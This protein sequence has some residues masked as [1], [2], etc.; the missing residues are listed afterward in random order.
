MVGTG[1]DKVILQ[2]FSNLNDS[3]SAQFEGLICLAR[4]DTGVSPKSFVAQPCVLTT[5]SRSPGHLDPVGSTAD[6]ARQQV[7]LQLAG[8][9]RAKRQ[10]Q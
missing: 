4:D 5:Q 7:Q 9:E 8:R 6:G 3:M 10:H 2:V 1:L